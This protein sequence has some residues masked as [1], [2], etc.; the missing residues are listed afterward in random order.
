MM[1]SYRRKLIISAFL[2]LLI[3]VYVVLNS[4]HAYAYDK[5]VIQ[6]ELL[7]RLYAGAGGHVS[8]DWHGYVE[9]KGYHEGID[10]AFGRGKPI[11]AIFDGRVESNTS[12][13]FHTI[14][15]YNSEYDI[16]VVYLHSN[17]SV[18]SKDYVKKGD[19]IGT[20]S[21]YGAGGA[22]HTHVELR[23]GRWK[24]ASKSKYDNN[25]DTP[26]PY[27]L[28]E[29][30]FGTIMP[31]SCSCNPNYQGVYKCTTSISPLKIRSVHGE[32]YVK[33]G[34]IPP[35]AYVVVTS[36]NGT[37]AHVTYGTSSGLASMEYLER[38]D[39][40]SATMIGTYPISYKEG[41]IFNNISDLAK[42]RRQFANYCQN[43]VYGEN[44]TDVP[45]VF[46]VMKNVDGNT[47]VNLST[48]T[49]ITVQE[50][51]V[52][53]VI[54]QN[55]SNQMTFLTLTS[56]TG[57]N[58]V[59]RHVVNKSELRNHFNSNP[60]KQ[61]EIWGN[62]GVNIYSSGGTVLPVQEVAPTSYTPDVI[63]H[64]D[65]P[66]GTYDGSN[67]IEISGWIVSKYD[68]TYVM[69]ESDSFGQMN[70]SNNLQDAS[71]E[72]EG[73]GY[74]TYLIK[75]RFRSV[76]DRKYLQ[77]NTE[78]YIK[79][80]AGLSNGATSGICS[81]RF[82]VTSI[83]PVLINI[84]NP[85][86]SSF[87]AGKDV[88][89][90]GTI[91]SLNPI[92]DV[93]GRLDDING[94][95]QVVNFDLDLKE[96]SGSGTYTYGYTFSGTLPLS[97]V[98]IND[99]TASVFVTAVDANSIQKTTAR[100]FSIG[101]VVVGDLGNYQFNFNQDNVRIYG[102]GV[103][104][105]SG[106]VYANGPIADVMAA[107][108]HWSGENNNKQI[109]LMAN[110]QEITPPAGYQY[111]KSFSLRVSAGDLCNVLDVDGFGDKEFRV[112][113]WADLVSD[114]GQG[115]HSQASS[116]RTVF[117]TNVTRP[118]YTV[119]YDGNGGSGAP[120][121]GSFKHGNGI[122]ISSS[123]PVRTGYSFRGWTTSSS[124]NIV[125]YVPQSS[126]NTNRSITLYAVWEKASIIPTDLISYNFNSSITI[127]NAAKVYKFVPSSKTFYRFTASGNVGCNVII[128]NSSG[129]TVAS[130]SN[131]SKAIKE[132]LL[133]DNQ[134]YYLVIKP[135]STTATG[136]IA[137]N[138]VR[139][140]PVSFDLRGGTGGPTGVLY[141]YAGEDLKLPDTIPV[142]QPITVTFQNGE[143]DAR[144]KMYDVV[145]TGWSNYEYNQAK[146][147]RAGEYLNE[148]RV[149][150]LT[151]EWEYSMLGAVDEP[152]KEGWIFDGWQNENGYL[153][154]GGTLILE[155]I[156][157]KPIW[158]P[159][160]TLE[161]LK[162]SPGNVAL[163]VGDTE[164][165]YVSALPEGAILPELTWVSSNPEVATISSDGVATIL[166]E[167]V[168]LITAISAEDDNFQDVAVISVGN[169]E[170]TIQY[171][172]NGGENG[173]EDR[174]VPSG[175]SISI[176]EKVPVR[177]GY[178]FLG[179]NYSNKADDVEFQPGDVLTVDRDR[180]LYAVWRPN[181]FTISF[182]ANGGE[183]VPEPQIKKY[184]K[185]LILGGEIPVREG[186]GFAGWSTDPSASCAEYPAGGVFEKD[187]ETVLFAVWLERTEGISLN[188]STLA[189]SIGERKTLKA[190]VTPE[191]AV[192]TAVKWISSD[193]D[194][195]TVNNGTVTAVSAG[196][197]V[198][199]CTVSE[200]V[201]VSAS[202]RVR[203]APQASIEGILGAPVPLDYSVKPGDMVK[204]S[205]RFASDDA[206][207]AKILYSYDETV[208]E[209]VSASSEGSYVTL[210]N[211]TA[212]LAVS[213][214][215]IPNGKQAELTFRILDKAEYGSYKV[216][217][218]V[219]ECYTIGEVDTNLFAVAVDSVRLSCEQHT[220]EMIT[221]TPA[222]KYKD[223]FSAGWRC[224]VC[225]EILTEQQ[226][227]KVN[228][229]CWL[230]ED[231]TTIEE[232]AFMGMS[233]KQVIVSSNT[234]S[235]GDRAFKDCEQL[236]I[237]VIPETVKDIGD[238]IFEGSEQVV[239]ITPKGSI[240]E[241]YA[242]DNFIPFIA[243]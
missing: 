175:E 234:N 68:L 189:L 208:M 46:A 111:A 215:K 195:V 78:Y 232:E 176:P 22:V 128:Q 202:C 88:T 61:A 138:V 110:V 69:C 131:V 168:S 113:F 99:T 37:W 187:Q 1:T 235:I 76:I 137:V 121:S 194:V 31:E 30:Y 130:M 84:S 123:I 210:G 24:G 201:D 146:F 223:G 172:T 77:P 36:A 103:Q 86:S 101:K 132:V 14:A 10:C 92:S 6:Q 124:S 42:A 102:S 179:W 70:L 148:N 197:A 178:N 190:T 120:D 126:Y 240:A 222:T 186:Y 139:S 97:Q 165:F 216:D 143:D 62:T 177:T 72:L 205:L 79:V 41:D 229:C 170:F 150:T 94:S 243:Q 90:S 16:T 153:Y 144:Q 106:T 81:Q 63:V 12:D 191:G 167:G 32:N 171:D 221:P 75:K 225:G 105:I 166:G 211:K 238:N 242:M 114:S 19:L 127:K 241:K 28:Y 98:M 169:G 140:Y 118:S 219:V 33:V 203:V 40:L 142:H 213:N 149:I 133:N 45:N 217:V 198:I 155:D 34:E 226:V 9:I 185:P 23:P 200:N 3:A 104:T 192:G 55:T 107:V 18:S 108:Y 89:V 227:I 48:G 122:T 141:Q 228:Q 11:H 173:P 8:C 59:T 162:I 116:T 80:W 85:S 156:V 26:N 71:A 119:S 183:G 136:T 73:A 135:Y 161:S 206:A 145:F 52:V 233:A 109:Q 231:L 220:L 7:N 74:G 224:S 95:S 184:E 151:A 218:A 66:S 27:P 51:N 29:K 91:F 54:A 35:G 44:Y 209:L 196:D 53:Y 152:E 147:W 129:N 236:L 83:A 188:Y 181:E 2:L 204:L 157:L 57:G 87:T 193:E 21:D 82:N 214:G 199:T 60:L 207:Y 239:I 163:E 237:V 174:V 115:V 154:S 159:A 56:G 230:P 212:V 43:V 158:I 39:D 100:T 64:I 160:V 93:I 117:G 50:N 49:V 180:T 38:Q 15:I 67:H 182:N 20:E 112:L 25:Q 65:N 134:T 96:G 5:T 58:V 125:K 47:I 13:G 17:P 4:R 164:Q